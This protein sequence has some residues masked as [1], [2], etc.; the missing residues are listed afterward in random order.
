MTKLP[1]KV[2]IMGIAFAIKYVEVLE[3]TEDDNYG[4]MCGAERIIKIKKSLT[5]AQ[6][7]VTIFHE[8]IHAVLYISGQS[9]TLT[10]EQEEGLVLALEH[11]LWPLIKLK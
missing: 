6:K 10:D 5:N 7:F 9:E 11:G 8:T 4:E 3:K 2:N 1:T